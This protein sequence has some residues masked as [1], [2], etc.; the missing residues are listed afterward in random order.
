MGRLVVR[1]KSCRYVTSDHG[2]GWHPDALVRQDLQAQFLRY[3]RQGLSDAKV[4]LAVGV[5][6]RTISRWRAA[7]KLPANQTQIR[8]TAA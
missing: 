7:R 4:A 8:R 3:Y 5:S 2:Q 1:S 6:D